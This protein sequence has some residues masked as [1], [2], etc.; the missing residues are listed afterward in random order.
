MNTNTFKSYESRILEKCKSDEIEEMTMYLQPSTRGSIK[1]AC[2]VRFQ[3]GVDKKDW[4]VLNRFFKFNEGENHL[5]VLEK[6]D[7]DRFRPIDNFLKGRVGSIKGPS[8]ELLSWLID[9]SPRPFLRFKKEFSVDAN[10]TNSVP[11]KQRVGKGVT[12]PSAPIAKIEKSKSRTEK[13]WQWT[14]VLKITI[15]LAAVVVGGLLVKDVLSNGDFGKETEKENKYM[16]TGPLQ[17]NLMS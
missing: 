9:F 16:D 15:T 13:K 4:P 2:I 12:K 3:Q 14:L 7:P 6:A 5:D 10:T 8:L 11:V 1:E 17:R